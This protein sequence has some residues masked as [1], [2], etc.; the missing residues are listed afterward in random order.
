[1]VSWLGRHHIELVWDVT[2]YFLLSE[3][4]LIC[5]SCRSAR[6]ADEGKSRSNSQGKYCKNDGGM[7]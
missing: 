7:C 2:K 3:I 4:V 5:L 1:M 6:A